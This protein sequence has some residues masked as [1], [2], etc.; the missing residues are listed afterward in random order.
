GGAA[1]QA[2]AIV[3]ARQNRMA[4]SMSIALGSS[5]QLALLVA[6]LLVLLSYVMGPQ[7]MSL[8]FGPGLVL[9]V[10][11]AVIIAAQIVSDGR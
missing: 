8:E 1:E 11:V 7:P 10:L 2:T 5:V 9:S 4:L 3:S 6:P